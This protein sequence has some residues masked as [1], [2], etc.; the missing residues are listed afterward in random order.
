MLEAK[1]ERQNEAHEFD[2][3]RQR[4]ILRQDKVYRLELGVVVGVL[5]REAVVPARRGRHGTQ[6][7]GADD[8]K[9]L[10]DLGISVR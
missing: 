3:S 4:L 8:L 2:Q 5:D 10:R 7:V 6:E 9:P 1:S